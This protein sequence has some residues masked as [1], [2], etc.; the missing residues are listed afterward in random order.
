[1]L[2]VCNLHPVVYIDV[3][4]S[5]SQMKRM[6]FKFM[7]LSKNVIKFTA[8]VAGTVA[9][10]TVAVATNA[11]ADEIYTVQ[12]GDTLSEISYKYSNDLSMVDTLTQKNSIA[13]KNLIYVG[14]KL[15]IED[16]GD[17]HQ[18]T[19]QEVATTPAASSSAT[20]SSAATSTATSTSSVATST[21]TSTST[22]A[23]SQATSASQSTASQASSSNTSTSSSYTSSASGSEASAK[24]AIAAR[25]SGGSYTATNGQYVGKYQLS[26]SY[27]NGDYSAANQ[28][29]VADSYVARSYGSWSAALAHSNATGWY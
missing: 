12:S 6:V 3:D 9:L 14:Q 27:L 10:G 15:M 18:A 1:M 11:S 23:T 25:E 4:V 28:E 29:R 17:V 22:T 24:A 26:S 20:T 5:N 7:K 2:Y 13:D 16:N 19:Q 21:A 8:A